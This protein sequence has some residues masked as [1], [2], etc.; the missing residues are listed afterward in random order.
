MEVEICWNSMRFKNG[1]LV[2]NILRMQVNWN[3]NNL[4]PGFHVFGNLVENKKPRR[5][6]DCDFLNNLEKNLPENLET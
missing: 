2:E 5:R 4:S 6:A 1:N 3:S